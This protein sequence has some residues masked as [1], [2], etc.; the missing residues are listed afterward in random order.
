MDP[1]YILTAELDPDSFAWFDGLRRAHFPPE[2]IVLPAHVTLFHRLSSAQ[3]GHLATF[4]FPT[5]PYPSCLMRR[6]CSAP[7]SLSASDAARRLHRDMSGK[8]EHRKGTV[9]GLLVW[10][11][12]GGPWKLDRR[13]SFGD[14]LKPEARDGISIRA[15]RPTARP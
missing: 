1:T 13:L 15:T 14:P 2:R 5:I 8:F 9:A 11:Y 3:T 10:E 7:A 4:G 6:S 12:L